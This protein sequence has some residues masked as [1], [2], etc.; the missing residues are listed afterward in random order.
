LTHFNLIEVSVSG[1]YWK[2]VIGPG[3]I[4]SLTIPLV[5]I[6]VLL[7]ISPLSS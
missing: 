1:I 4:I 2:F 7:N 5:E 3:G 6:P